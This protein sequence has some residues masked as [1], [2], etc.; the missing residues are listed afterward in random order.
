MDGIGVGAPARVAHRR[1]VIDVDAEPEVRRGHILQQWL[2]AELVD[3]V[4]DLQSGNTFELAFVIR[5]KNQIF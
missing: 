3:P 5:H 2:A 1:D 4:L